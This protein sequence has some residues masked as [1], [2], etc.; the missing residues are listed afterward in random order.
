[1]AVTIRQCIVC[2]CPMKCSRSNKYCCSN[3]CHSR[4]HKRRAKLGLTTKEII[5]LYREETKIT[6]NPQPTEE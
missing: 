2:N 6:D 1:M 3:L 4:M 5:D